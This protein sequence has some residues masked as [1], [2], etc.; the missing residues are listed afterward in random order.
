MSRANYFALI[1]V[2]LIVIVLVRE[3]VRWRKGRRDSKRS[4]QKYYWQLGNTIR[5]FIDGKVHN[6]RDDH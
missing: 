5:T 2:L 1:G 6:R 3:T 4:T